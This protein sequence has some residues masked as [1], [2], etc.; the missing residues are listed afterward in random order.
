M[1]QNPQDVLNAAIAHCRTAYAGFQQ[2]AARTDEALYRAI[3]EI[4]SL[5]VRIQTDRALRAQFDELL[6]NAVGKYSN[7]ALFLVKYTFFPDTLQTGPGHKAD[8]NKAS[9]Y[10]KL[11]NRA[12]AHNIQPADFV[13][14]AREHGIQQT[15]LAARKFKPSRPPQL[16]STGRGGASL[17]AP[18]DAS[19]ASFVSHGFAP[20]ETW[21]YSAAVT[22]RLADA[23][24]RAVAAPQKLTVTVY[25]NDERAV[26]TGVTAQPWSGRFPAGAVQLPRGHAVEPVAAVPAAGTHVA[27]QPPQ[28]AAVRLALRRAAIPRFALS[29]GRRHRTAD[30]VVW[31]NWRRPH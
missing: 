30:G 7:E 27:L 14:F 18:T 6:L 22:E 24:R 21:C 1:Q 8:I 25:V 31:P 13:A 2:L 16:A 26:V 9:R 23:V 3:G 5:K 12:S 11:I 15:A 19:G 20:V 29:R 17:D 28:P 10:A 4:Y